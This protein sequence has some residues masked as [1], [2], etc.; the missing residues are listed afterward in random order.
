MDDCFVSEIQLCLSVTIVG[1]EKLLTSWE[2]KKRSLFWLSDLPISFGK[3][4]WSS[5]SSVS[6]RVQIIKFQ[7]FPTYLYKN[8][9][10][11]C[12]VSLKQLGTHCF[13]SN[14]VFQNITWLFTRDEKINK[15]YSH[16]ILLRVSLNT[17]K[18][19]STIF[20]KYCCASH[21]T[22]EN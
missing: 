3:M 13:F 9:Y 1:S 14:N 2:K 12:D 8:I 5:F 7:N 11:I 22:R 21:R 16:K 6:S 15:Y 4:R 18:L 10:I 19:C 20:T 17:G